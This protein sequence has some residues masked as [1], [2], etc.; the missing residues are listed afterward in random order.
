MKKL[1]ALAITATALAGFFATP[2]HAADTSTTFSLTSG[3]LSVS[4]PASGSLSSVAS[5]ASS[6]SA[7]LGAVTVTDARGAL[8]GIWSASAAS[9]DFVTG[10]ATADE[11]IGKARVTYLAPVPTIVSGTVVP[12]TGGLKTLDQSRTVVTAASIIGNN[13]V[14]WNPTVAISLPAQAVAGTYTGTITHSIA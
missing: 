10:T 5:G 6:I 14:S 3:A 2:A 11:T 13:V 4:A 7:N 8:A 1:I 9:T 12:V